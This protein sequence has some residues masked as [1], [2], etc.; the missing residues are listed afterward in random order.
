MRAPP[1]YVRAVGMACPVGL[2]WASACAALRA[3]ITRKQ[4]SPFVDNQGREVVI[5]HLRD[6]LD[7][8]STP[9]QR[10][11]F[12]LT[13]ALQEILGQVGTAAFQRLPLLVALPASLQGKPY[14]TDFL[15]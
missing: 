9:T 13:H 2:R 1:V 12:F 14:S 4:V 5:S 15:A 8:K 7:L 10:W 3:G 6:F 11:L